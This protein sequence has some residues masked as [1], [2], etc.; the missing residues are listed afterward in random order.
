[1]QRVYE[2][3]RWPQ[4]RR[5]ALRRAGH[6]CQAIEQGRRCPERTSLHAH[7]DYPG[8]LEQMLADGADPFDESRL[9]ILCATHHGQVEA[10]LRAES[11]R[12]THFRR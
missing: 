11:R 12:K 5:R 7:H 8:G 1:V 3:P 10:Y 6:R 9:V 4:A 2:S